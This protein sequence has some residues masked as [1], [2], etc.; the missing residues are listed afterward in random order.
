LSTDGITIGEK[1][2]PA[3][4]SWFSGEKLGGKPPSVICDWAVKAV[5]RASITS[6]F[7]I[8]HGMSY[9]NSHWD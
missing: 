3:R 2:F 8:N 5:N 6:R 9:S 4:T 1:G 7:R